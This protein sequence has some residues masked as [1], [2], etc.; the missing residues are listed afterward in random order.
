MLGNNRL[1]TLFVAVFLLII[2]LLDRIIKLSFIKAPDITKSFFSW[3]PFGIEPYQNTGS[4]FGLEIPLMFLG[5]ISIILLLVVGIMVGKAVIALKS[6]E[7]LGWGMV[8]MGGL[9][10]FLDRVKYG[11]VLDWWE[12]PWQAVI[13]LA[14]VYITVGVVIL[15]LSFRKEQKNTEK[16]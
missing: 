11:F 1:K 15:F 2:Y 12:M 13:N 4:M 5:I 9:S 14:D 16:V 10:N 6:I 7:I 8:F 3:L